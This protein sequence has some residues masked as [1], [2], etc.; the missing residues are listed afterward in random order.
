MLEHEDIKSIVELWTNDEQWDILETSEN[1]YFYKMIDAFEAKG[2]DELDTDDIHEILVQ[3][4]RE[5]YHNY[6]EDEVMQEAYT[7]TQII[8]DIVYSETEEDFED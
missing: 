7:Y 5:K 4:F 8:E 6:S 3:K 1:K 2:F